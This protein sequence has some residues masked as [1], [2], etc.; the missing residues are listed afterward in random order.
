MAIAQKERT[1][2]PVFVTVPFL[3]TGAGAAIACGLYGVFSLVQQIHAG[4]ACC[5]PLVTYR[6]VT[7]HLLV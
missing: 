3:I 6:T 1:V 7:Q 4:L 2:T 5:V